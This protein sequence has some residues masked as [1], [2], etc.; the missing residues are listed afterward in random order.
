MDLHDE[1]ISTTRLI[2]DRFHGCRHGFPSFDF[3]LTSSGAERQLRGLRIGIGE[4]PPAP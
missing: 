2:P 4:P 1:R 3:Q